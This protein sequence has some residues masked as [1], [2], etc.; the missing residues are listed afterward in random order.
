MLARNMALALAS[1]VSACSLLIDGES[2][3]LRCA[4]EGQVGPPACDVGMVCL[5]G[6]CRL[7]EPAASA[8]A[9]SDD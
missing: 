8:G 9:P 5:S 7:S 4:Q 3:P 2:T 1:L 6:S